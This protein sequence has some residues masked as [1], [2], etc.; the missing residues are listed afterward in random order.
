LSKWDASDEQ[1]YQGGRK[2]A[3]PTKEGE[4]SIKFIITPHAGFSKAEPDCVQRVQRTGGV[5]WLTLG[6][7]EAEGAMFSEKGKKKKS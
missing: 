4:L 1:E 6:G 7:G 3:V 2:P 5:R